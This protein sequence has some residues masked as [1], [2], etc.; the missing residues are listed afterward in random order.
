MED[1]GGAIEGCRMCEGIDRVG[2]DILI[3]LLEVGDLQ[4]SSSTGENI[5]RYRD[6]HTSEVATRLSL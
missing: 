2:Y 6:N 5:Q 1:E 3:Y 4:R